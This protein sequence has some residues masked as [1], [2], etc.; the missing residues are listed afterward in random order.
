MS[1]PIGATERIHGWGRLAGLR[2]HLREPEN[3]GAC[4]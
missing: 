2:E 4:T 3:T 1:E